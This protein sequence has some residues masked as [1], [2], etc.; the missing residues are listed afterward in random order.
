MEFL[1]QAR[2]DKAARDQGEM[3]KEDSSSDLDPK[4]LDTYYSS[5]KG[6]EDSSKAGEDSSSL[7]KSR[8]EAKSETK[9]EVA[10]ESEDD[11][12]NNKGRNM[13]GQEPP[14]KEDEKVEVEFDEYMTELD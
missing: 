8:S 14:K 1:Q 9:S 3:P 7:N 13:D 5:S 11:K 6:G 10:S 2:R 12:E 4:A